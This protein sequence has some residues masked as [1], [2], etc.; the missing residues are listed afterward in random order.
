LFDWREEGI[1]DLGV[2]DS[3]SL[4]YVTPKIWRD[5]PLAV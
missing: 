1:A 4:G 5:R 2:A 3:F